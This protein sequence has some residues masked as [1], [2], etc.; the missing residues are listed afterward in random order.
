M[1]G[2]NETRCL[3]LY[4]FH[5]HRGH[6]VFKSHGTLYVAGVDSGSVTFLTDKLGLFKL[7]RQEGHRRAST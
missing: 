7:W 3:I 1:R 6:T 4:V 2:M 5:G